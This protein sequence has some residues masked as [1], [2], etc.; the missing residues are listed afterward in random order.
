MR[1]SVLVFCLAVLGSL[2]VST[3]ALAQTPPPGDSDSP[4][5]QEAYDYSGL[6]TVEFEDAPELQP[7]AEGTINPAVR[8]TTRRLPGGRAQITFNQPIRVVVRPRVW[9]V[10]L[11]VRRGTAPAGATYDGLDDND[12][13]IPDD[14]ERRD[15]QID[16]L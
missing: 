9:G 4:S 15:V 12:N 13:G 11:P 14:L 6:E 10:S 5:G 16:P 2:P 3:I 7:V 1:R 8:R